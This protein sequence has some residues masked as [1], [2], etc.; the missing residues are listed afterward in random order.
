MRGI[1]VYLDQL[2]EFCPDI[3]SVWMIGERADDEALGACSPFG[4]DLLAFADSETLDRLR[5][6]TDLHRSDICLR[7][8]LDGNRFEPAWGDPSLA[9]SLCDWRWR[10]VSER[11]ALYSRNS[12]DATRSAQ[13][14]IRLFEGR[15]WVRATAGVPP[16]R[17][18]ERIYA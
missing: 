14:A 5:E 17:P 18:G 8:V 3:H 6:E 13:R 11:E 12:L 9:G 15:S 10:H 2:A 16:S 4:W 7:V 1:S